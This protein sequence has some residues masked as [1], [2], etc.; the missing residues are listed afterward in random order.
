MKKTSTLLILLVLALL[1]NVLSAQDATPEAVAPR[2]EPPNPDLVVWN[3]VASGLDR[4]LFLTNAGDG[5]GRLFIGEQGGRIMILNA[6]GALSDTPFLD[7]SS[8]LSSDVFGG[9]YTERGLLGLAFHPDYVTNGQFF[10]YYTDVNGNTV[11]ARYTAS[12]DNPDAADPASATIIFTQA[13]PYPN[14]NGGQLAFGLDGYLYIGL[15]D[16]GSQGDPQGNGQNLASYLGKIL[17]IDVNADTYQIPED[18][19]F[20]GDPNALPEIWSYGFRNPWRFSFD[21]VTGDLYMAD[22]GQNQWEEINF[23]PASSAGGE[24]YGWNL[25]EASTRYSS[26]ARPDGLTMP[27]AEY[28]HNSGACSVSGGYVYRGEALPEMQGA[29]F[30]GDW[31][32]GRIW[33]TY[34]GADGVWNTNVFMNTSYSISAFGEDEQGELYL[35]NYYGGAVLRMERAG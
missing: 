33:T 23:Q 35:I 25:Y 14:H 21:R 4:P 5:S 17:R 12:A 9:G 34:Q 32:I 18:N 24:N 7:V 27:I 20:V 6:A 19:P 29:Y 1:T 15:G 16:G 31:C 28:N 13:Q 3:E 22:V 8:L 26:G 2:S 30:F 11:V 10:I